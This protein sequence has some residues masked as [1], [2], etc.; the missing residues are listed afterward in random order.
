MYSQT[1]TQTQIQTLS[2]DDI[3]GGGGG[4]Y[5]GRGGDAAT[6]PDG[7]YT[8][9]QEGGALA[10]KPL[11]GGPNGGESKVLDASTDP[12]TDVQWAKDGRHIAYIRQNNVWVVA[13]SGGAPL[14][15]THDVPG[16]GDPRGAADS[17]IQWNPNGTWILFESGKKGYNEIYAVS[18]DGKGP[19]LIAA[20]EIYHGKDAIAPNTVVDSGD[21]VSSDRFDAREQWSP[22][23]TRISYTERSREFF[24]GKLKVVTF[25]ARKGAAPARRS[26]F[27]SHRTI[28]AERG[29]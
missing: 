11:S 8:L 19:N 25:D 7:K 5:R 23:G 1:Q 29:R 10:V 13:V 17:H 22:D 15:L 26:I 14:Q 28:R 2:L 6:S 18:E 4:G 12:K 16:P 27:T 3:L 20:T 9:S 21:A 24:S